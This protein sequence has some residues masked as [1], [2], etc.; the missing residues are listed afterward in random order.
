ML[1]LRTFVRPQSEHSQYG[2]NIRE[3][4]IKELAQLDMKGREIKNTVK[5]TRLLASQKEVPL[6][7]KHV[8]TV[9]R[10]ND[11]CSIAGKAANI[12]AGLMDLIL[13]YFWVMSLCLRKFLVL[14]DNGKFV[15]KV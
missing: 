15:E 7:V 9:L 1:V 6:A 13:S 3:N 14:L 5:K 4:I 2:S 10:A 12:S 11:G 8:A